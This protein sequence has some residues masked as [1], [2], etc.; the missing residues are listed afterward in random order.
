VFIA[1]KDE[2]MWIDAQV[3]TL[4]LSYVRIFLVAVLSRYGKASASSDMIDL[5]QSGVQTVLS[6]LP[7]VLPDMY[8]QQKRLG[9][10][11]ETAM[12]L[13]DNNVW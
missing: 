11:D 12:K 9:Y 13:F 6:C 4:P 7:F 5:Y 2:N 1:Q 3:D 10:V 8:A